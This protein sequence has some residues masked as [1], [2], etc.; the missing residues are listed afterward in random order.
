M[1]CL[2][3]KDDNL[4]DDPGFLVLEELLNDVAADRTCPNDGEFSVSRHE[5]ILHY[6]LC[7]VLCGG[8]DLLYPLLS[9]LFTL[10][11]HF[12]AS[13][14]HFYPSPSH[15]QHHLFPS[16][17]RQ[18]SHR[19]A[20]GAPRQALTGIISVPPR[21]CKWPVGMTETKFTT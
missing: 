7:G 21:M 15:R 13:V 8:L 9:Y 2:T 20:Y 10:F 3:S 14:T 4:L 12:P 1:L 11:I 17:G 16:R 6:L 19:H 18:L 5:V